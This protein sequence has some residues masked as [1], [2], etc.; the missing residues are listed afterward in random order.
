MGLA[1]GGVRSPWLIEFLS[2]WRKCKG[3]SLLLKHGVVVSAQKTI[4]F[5][6]HSEIGLGTLGSSSITCRRPTVAALDLASFFLLTLLEGSDLF[7]G[8]F[9]FFGLLFFLELAACFLDCL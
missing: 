8:G 3:R 7:S 9:L 2:L 6:L 4:S 5:L 1:L